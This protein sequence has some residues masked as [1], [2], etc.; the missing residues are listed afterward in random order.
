MKQVAINFILVTSI[1]AIG[2]C[3]NPIRL[4]TTRWR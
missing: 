4:S 2:S 1:V 3:Q